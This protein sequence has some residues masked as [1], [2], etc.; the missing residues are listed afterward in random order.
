MRAV[1]MAGGEGTRLRPLTSNQPKPMVPICGKPCIEHIV[2]LVHRYGIDDVVVT[3]AFMPQVIRSYLGDGSALGVR[4]EYAVEEQPLGTAGSVRNARELLTETFVVIS[5]DALCDFDLAEIVAFHR[6]RGGARDAR[7]EVGRQ[8]ARVRRRDHRRAGPHRAIPREAVLGPGLLGHDQHGRLRDR[9]RAAR[10]RP[11]GRAVRLLQAALPRAARGGRAA[12]RLRRARAPLLE[13][14]RD[15]RAVPRGEPGRARRPRRRGRSRRAPEGEHLAR[16]GR[17]AALGRRDRGPCLPRRV[18]D[19]RGR[20]AGRA[21][22]RA[23]RER[24]G[25]G[26]CLG[27]ALGD[28][29]RHAHRLVGH[30][31]RVDRRAATATCARASA[32]TRAPRSAT[33]A[34]SARRP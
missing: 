8:P 20:R 23:R 29:R 33:S 32:S 26:R 17:D 14:H 30:R 1:V 10:P 22:R 11:R 18:H 13:G 5:G 25:Q 3:L 9:A 16:R 24:D 7:A 2:E 6:E 19:G 21:L 31:S 27:A 28:R 34:S 4:I 12:V 15:D